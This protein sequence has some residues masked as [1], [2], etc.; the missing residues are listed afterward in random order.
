M[1]SST[2]SAMLCPPTPASCQSA[3]QME[4][5]D[6]PTGAGHFVSVS[7]VAELHHV[8]DAHSAVAIIVVVR[9][10]ERAEGIDGEFIVIAEVMGEHL[11][12]AAV[13]VAAEDH[14]LAVGLASVGHL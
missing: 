13:E 14:A 4:P 7:E 1:V 6:A 9:L 8:I 3:V 12:F 2:R 5:A 11:E 10:P